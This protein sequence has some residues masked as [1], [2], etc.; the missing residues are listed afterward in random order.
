MEI[1]THLAALVLGIAVGF[2]GRKYL[3]KNDPAALAEADAMVK[4]AGDQARER[5]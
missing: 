2:W 3:G 5:F 1:I 4:K